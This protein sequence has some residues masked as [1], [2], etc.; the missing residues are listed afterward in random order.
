MGSVITW[1]MPHPDEENSFLSLFQAGWK[2]QSVGR[3]LPGDALSRTVGRVDK[4][5]FAKQT[6]SVLRGL[7]G[8]IWFPSLQ[9]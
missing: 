3:L 4:E 8:D 7:E 9:R 2:D 5:F 6:M 1:S